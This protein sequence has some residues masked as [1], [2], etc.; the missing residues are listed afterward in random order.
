MGLNLFSLKR[1]SSSKKTRE[2]LA[3]DNYTQQEVANL[4]SSETK[5]VGEVEE[6]IIA[7]PPRKKRIWLYLL[8]GLGIL[9]SG[10]ILF[11]YLQSSAKEEETVITEAAKLPVRTT[12][13]KIQP[14]QKLTIANSEQN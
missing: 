5:A 6:T 9:A 8:L 3:P 13:V 14:L 11:Q 12:K 2:E 7:N 1:L 10:G 4:P